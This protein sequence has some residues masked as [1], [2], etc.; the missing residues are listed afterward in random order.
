M[1]KEPLQFS[2]IF[3][4]HNLRNASSNIFASIPAINNMELTRREL[5]LGSSIIAGGIAGCLGTQRTTTSIHIKNNSSSDG[6]VELAVEKL[7]GADIVYENEI[8]IDQ[9]QKKKINNKV[10][11]DDDLLVLIS[12]GESLS[13]EYEWTNTQSILNININN[14]SIGF[15]VDN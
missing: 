13:D 9:S 8:D 4:T 12:T 11:M 7:S 2:A 15:N 6:T 1:Y 10:T 14:D 3:G 5:L